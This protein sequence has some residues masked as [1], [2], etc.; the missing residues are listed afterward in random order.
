[1]TLVLAPLARDCDWTKWNNWKEKLSIVINKENLENETPSFKQFI[2]PFGLEIIRNL[3][4]SVRR[5]VDLK[6][7]TNSLI[8]LKMF[9]NL[10]YSQ[11]FQMNSNKRL[12]TKPSVCQIY[13]LLKM[14]KK[15][16][17]FNYVKRTLF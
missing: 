10:L 14:K 3:I 6:I 11:F 17:L 12:E 2:G 8:G 1:M 9:A 15:Q 4:S 13:N 5:F 16:Y 7:Q